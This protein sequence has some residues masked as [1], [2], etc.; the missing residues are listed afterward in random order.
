MNNKE[1]LQKTKPK[2]SSIDEKNL[3]EDLQA[4]YLSIRRLKN[5]VRHKKITLDIERKW[6]KE[7]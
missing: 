3:L 7:I 6:K 2:N 4:A 1:D 5:S